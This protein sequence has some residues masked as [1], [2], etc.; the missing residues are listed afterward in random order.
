MKT[1]LLT[2]ILGS[3]IGLSANAAFVCDFNYTAENQ[4]I[5][6]TLQLETI[7]KTDLLTM[8]ERNSK[9]LI[10]AFHVEGIEKTRIGSIVHFYM[11]ADN[12]KIDGGQLVL[13]S[14]LPGPGQIIWGDAGANLVDCR[15]L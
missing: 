1:Q 14:V 13:P 7:E 11:T 10:T 6:S 4:S 8:R 12:I 5:Q 2:A 9:E 3:L 15:N